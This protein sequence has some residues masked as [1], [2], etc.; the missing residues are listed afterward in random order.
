ME[1]IK[2]EQL[3]YLVQ[4]QEK[5]SQIIEITEKQKTLPDILSSL[6]LDLEKGQ[7]SLAEA[8]R[9]YENAT[10]ER[11]NL[12]DLLQDAEERIKKLKGRV[13]EIKTNKEYQALLKEIAT[14]EQEKSDI[15]EKIIILLEEIDNLKAL[16]TDREHIITEEEKKFQEKKKKI[17]EDFQQWSERLKELEGQKA[18]LGS[19]IDPKLLAEYN[20]LIST[21]KGLAVTLVQNEYCL[22]CHMRV[23]PQIFTEIRKNDKIIYCL[24]CRRVLY[25]KP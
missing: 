15:E 18:L 16:C 21:R 8:E 10:K 24:N 14:A 1:F 7:G 12:E 4:I 25:W 11:K 9:E 13:S 19:Q 2:N 22:G 23:P 17:E 5:D 6:R 20:K 3:R